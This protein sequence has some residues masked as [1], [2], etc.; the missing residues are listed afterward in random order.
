M[1]NDILHRDVGACNDFPQRDCNAYFSTGWTAFLVANRLHEQ[2][3]K[4][5]TPEIKPKLEKGT[6]IGHLIKK[7]WYDVL[8]SEAAPR[9][10]FE[11]LH[12]GYSWFQGLYQTPWNTLSDLYKQVE[13]TRE[14]GEYTLL[15][16]GRNADGKKG[17][18]PLLP[19]A[20]AD[21]IAMLSDLLC[22]GVDD[23]EGN[24]PNIRP[25]ACSINRIGGAIGRALSEIACVNLDIDLMNDVYEE[26]GGK[27][28]LWSTLFHQL[29][30]AKQR[31]DTHETLQLLGGDGKPFDGSFVHKPTQGKHEYGKAQ[32][33]PVLTRLFKG[34]QG[35]AE[36][37][38]RWGSILLNQRDWRL[39]L[40]RRISEHCPVEH[41]N[42]VWRDPCGGAWQQAVDWGGNRPRCRA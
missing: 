3:M 39:Q 28:G 13:R 19:C 23:S 33:N 2:L 38:R 26:Y 20:L 10:F 27:I 6:G 29:R 16:M 5:T 37:H 41:T 42:G 12:I 31:V 32:A 25:D 15:N 4:L 35:V 40:F 1:L 9:P 30:G 22:Y 34:D 8:A 11:Q 24:G 14:E 21:V 18:H 7:K 36:A 17:V